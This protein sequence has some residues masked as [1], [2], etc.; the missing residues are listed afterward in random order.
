M[1]SRSGRPSRLPAF[2]QRFIATETASG[3]VLLAATVLALAWANS[4]VRDS[5]AEVFTDDVVHV[6]NDGLM[7]LFFLVVGMEIKRELVVGELRSPRVAALPV[8]GALGGMVVP[9]LVY[10]AFNAGQPGSSGWAIPMATDIAFALGVLALLGSRVPASGR[11]FL[12][13]LAVVDDIGAIAVIALFY[14]GGVHPTIVAVAVGLLVPAKVG[15]A[16]SSPAERWTHR[17][18]PWS[19]FVVVP[20][21]A[22]ANAG[23]Q[24]SGDALSAPG[25]GA[26]SL[27]VAAGLVLGKVVGIAGVC[28]LAVRIGLARLPEDL[29]WPHLLGTAALGG[30][31]FTVSLFV[32]SL[33]FTDKPALEAA[34]KLG[35]LGGS[36]LAALLGVAL[37]LRGQ[38]HRGR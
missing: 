34:A 33:A 17:L 4:P 21:F 7:A 12:L 18:H 25:A 23:V 5:Y 24:L 16:G 14:S 36:L 6:V 13:T 35:V 10:V 15:A 11:L 38:G 31:G 30:I 26:V 20:L 22:L 3:V 8:V 1:P 29:G 9:A 28:W 2:A 27:G 32:T 19:S 37:L